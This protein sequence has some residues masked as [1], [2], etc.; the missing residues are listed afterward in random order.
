MMR[1]KVAQTALFLLQWNSSSRKA[2]AGWVRATEE[3][4]PAMKRRKNQR[5]PKRW[6]RGIF[7]KI[8]GKA[9]KPKSKAP[10]WAMA[11]VPSMPKKA[12]AAGMA[13][14]PPR[15]TSANSLVE[16]VVI[17]LRVMSSSS[18]R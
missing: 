3:V 1:Q 11:L 16:A 6:P 14:V 10:L 12:T 8:T 2:M 9:W 17:P 15:M 4:I 5:A 13:M 7:W 18:L